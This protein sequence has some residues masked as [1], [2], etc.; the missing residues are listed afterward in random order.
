MS[1]Y[2]KMVVSTDGGVT[3]IELL[4]GAVVIGLINLGMVMIHK[5]KSKKTQSQD[6]QLEVNAAVA[7]Y[8]SLRGD[9]PKEE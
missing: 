6:I 4:I 9:E 2:E 1:D 5:S 3:W 7:N 8:F